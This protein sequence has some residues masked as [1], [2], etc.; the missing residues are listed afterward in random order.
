MH[1]LQRERR[2][3]VVI[4]SGRP[5]L[6]GIVASS[7]WRDFRGIGELSGVR[8]AVALFAPRRR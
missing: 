8:V 4:E 5:P 6:V 7:A 1:A 3:R 2:T